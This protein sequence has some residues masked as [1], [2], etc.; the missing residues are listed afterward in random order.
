[1]LL[2]LVSRERR[3]AARDSAT[4]GGDPLA[5]ARGPRAARDRSTRDA[6]MRL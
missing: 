2:P 1:M 4:A 6:R 3:R 5:R